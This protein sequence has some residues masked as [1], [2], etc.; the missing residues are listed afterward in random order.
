MSISEWGKPACEF[1]SDRA[2]LGEAVPKT[3]AFVPQLSGQ[4]WGSLLSVPRFLPVA[5]R[6]PLSRW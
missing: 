6:L 1:L 2:F 3:L 5:P 4:D